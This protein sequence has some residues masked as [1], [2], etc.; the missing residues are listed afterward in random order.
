[1]E[2]DLSK[3][4]TCRKLVD[5]ALANQAKMQEMEPEAGW[6]DVDPISTSVAVLLACDGQ[7]AAQILRMI[8]KGEI[9]VSLVVAGFHFCCQA[10]SRL[11]SSLLTRICEIISATGDAQKA[12]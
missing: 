3:A 12:S 6:E 9:N 11:A 10:T 2:P 5:Y 1:M 8:L 7:P 4:A